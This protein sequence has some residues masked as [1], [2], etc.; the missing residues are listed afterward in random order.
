MSQYVRLGKPGRLG[1]MAGRTNRVSGIRGS[2]G[3]RLGDDPYFDPTT[4]NDVF[5]PV[6][7]QPVP[8]DIN[9]TPTSG[10]YLPTLPGSSGGGLTTMEANLLSQA[11]NVGGQI[12]V[13][14]VSPTPMVT[15]N[16]ATGQY[17][18]TG[19]AVLPSGVASSTFLASLS[20]YLPLILLG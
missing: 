11:I 16:A 19:G 12:G 2:A 5:N 10:G 1:R 14:A 15:Y 9:L 20:S 7:L 3:L 18:A 13:R 8:T 4:G 6:T 17:T